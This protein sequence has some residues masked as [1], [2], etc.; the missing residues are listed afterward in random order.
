MRSGSRLNRLPGYFTRL[1]PKM[2]VYLCS[3][4]SRKPR[5]PLAKYELNYQIHN[6]YIVVVQRT[7]IAAG[8]Q[9]GGQCLSRFR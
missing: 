6:R 1:R 2:P 8:L 9:I 3:F 5:F 4:R 7:R